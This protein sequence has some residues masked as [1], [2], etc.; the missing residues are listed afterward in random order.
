MSLETVKWGAI[1]KK[2]GLQPFPKEYWV[3]YTKNYAC[4]AIITIGNSDEK[5]T[6]L[7]IT[8]YISLRVIFQCMLS[9]KVI[10]KKKLYNVQIPL[11]LLLSTK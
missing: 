4:G 11:L 8:L 7:R 1:K 5:V 10:L 3:S 6:F 9:P 2:G